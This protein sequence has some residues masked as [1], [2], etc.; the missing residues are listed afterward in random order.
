MVYSKDCMVYTHYSKPGILGWCF[1]EI[2]VW[3]KLSVNRRKLV[4]KKGEYINSLN[5]TVSR[6]SIHNAGIFSVAQLRPQVFHPVVNP[7]GFIDVYCHH[8]TTNTS[9]VG[10]WTGLR[11]GSSFGALGRDKDGQGA[12]LGGILTCMSERSAYVVSQ[13]DP[14]MHLNQQPSAGNHTPTATCS[15]ARPEAGPWDN[16]MWFRRI[17]RQ[18]RQEPIYLSLCVRCLLLLKSNS[19]T[20][21]KTVP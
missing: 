18:D 2:K 15:F 16:T 20:K 7:G 12:G 21:H 14:A 8:A 3:C 17:K 1:N 9:P 19:S 13:K 5:L 4:W 6:T 11:Q 10:G